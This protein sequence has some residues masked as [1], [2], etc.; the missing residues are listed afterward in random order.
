LSLKMTLDALL[1]IWHAKKAAMKPRSS[2]SITGLT[3]MLRMNVT[4]LHFI[5]PL[6][7]VI[8]KFVNNC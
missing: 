4:G 8:P 6:T 7:T 2:F 1:Y 3:S 5:T